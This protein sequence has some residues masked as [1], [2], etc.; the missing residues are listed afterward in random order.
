M[1]VAATG[2]TPLDGF[3]RDNNRAGLAAAISKLV[4]RPRK[5]LQPIFW[6]IV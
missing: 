4:Q 3:R 2:I 5:A 1:P 6:E